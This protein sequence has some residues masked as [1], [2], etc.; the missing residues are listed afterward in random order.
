MREDAERTEKNT[1]RTEITPA[2]CLAGA[3]CTGHLH[4]LQNHN[5]PMIGQERHTCTQT[6]TYTQTD[7]HTALAYTVNHRVR[8][9]GNG[10]LVGAY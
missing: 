2:A 1:K 5:Q 7:I 8:E 10:W 3:R 9:E 4:T 6:H